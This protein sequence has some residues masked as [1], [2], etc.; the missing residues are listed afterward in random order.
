MKHMLA[1]ASLALVGAVAV[2]GCG[3]GSNG[4][5]TSPTP[6]PTAS[7]VTVAIVSSTGN[8]AFQPNP[9]SA[10]S[11]ETVRFV[12]NDSETHHIVM[13]DGSADL[14]VV[15]P[16]SSSQ[17]LTV[18]NT[19]AVTFHCVLHSTMVGSINGQ[20]APETPPCNDPTGYTC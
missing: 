8:T 15:T 11:G 3:G 12:N 14:G 20:T 13:D 18:Q 16:G 6:P 19:N 4:S 17:G 2:W 10:R 1:G 5:P 9:V 7:T